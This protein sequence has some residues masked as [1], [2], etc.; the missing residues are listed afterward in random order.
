MSP[1]SSRRS[2]PIAFQVTAGSG[3]VTI[4]ELFIGSQSR[5]WPGSPAVKPSVARST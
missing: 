4:M 3:V 5:R 1:S 2:Q